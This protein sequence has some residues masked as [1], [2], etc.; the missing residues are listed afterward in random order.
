MTR[1]TLPEDFNPTCQKIYRESGVDF[2]IWVQNM[3]LQTEQPGRAPH[4]LWIF[5]IWARDRIIESGPFRWDPADRELTDL[6]VCNNLATFFLFKDSATIKKALQASTLPMDDII[7][8]CANHMLQELQVGV[9]EPIL[10][11]YAI[12]YAASNPQG[13]TVVLSPAATPNQMVQYAKGVND[14]TITVTTYV[15]AH[16]HHT[17]L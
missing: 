8:K 12:I 13:W 9:A 6:A 11:D 16:V 15:K 7:L 5:A 3:G 1:F 17:A 2:E 10:M 14:P 4:L